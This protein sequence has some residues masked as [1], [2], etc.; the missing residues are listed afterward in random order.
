MKESCTVLFTNILTALTEFLSLLTF[1]LSFYFTN[2]SSGNHILNLSER[3]VL[4]ILGDSYF[5]HMK[6]SIGVQLKEKDKQ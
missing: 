5:C 2:I 3:N 6:K 4:L 1:L